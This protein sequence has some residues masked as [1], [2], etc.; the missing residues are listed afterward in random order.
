MTY[1]TIF[2]SLLLLAGAFS[3]R[4]Q[5]NT[6][7]LDL[8]ELNDSTTTE[9]I[10]ELDAEAD[11][12]A[13]FPLP[14]MLPLTDLPTIAYLPVVFDGVK[15]LD[16]VDLTDIEPLLASPNPAMNWVKEEAARRDRARRLKQ[17]YMIARPWQVHYNI[18]TLPEPPKMY[19]ANIDPSTQTIT[20]TEVVA[21]TDDHA[22]QALTTVE[23]HRVNW[24][25]KFNAALQFSQAFI[26]PNWYQGGTNN[27]NILADINWNV[28]LNNKFYPDW[29]LEAT[30]I[31]KMGINNA[32]QDTI[33][34]YLIS[35][36]LFQFNGTVGYKA[37]KNWYY[38]MTAQFKTQ[39]FNNYKPNSN[40]MKA[41]FMT[42]GE[43]N[44][45]LGMTYN[46]KNDPRR[47]KLDMSI[48]PL[49]YNL[50]VA[51]NRHI[52]PGNFG[53]AE[54]RKSVSDIGSNAEVKISWDIMWNINYS[55]RFFV[56][57]DYSYAQGDWEN[58]LSFSVNR[59]FSTRIFW[60]LRYDSSR[61]SDSSWRQWQLKE[62][63][64]FG[65]SY[66]FKTI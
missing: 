14:E 31:Y 20:V 1:R 22:T 35:Q 52:P 4:A 51:T 11:T 26:S 13:G 36:D 53:I 60:H 43:L 47:F 16:P 12:L 8:L 6:S 7:L 40:T 17:A 63:L 34:K 65:L 41:A 21:I 24:L 23:E 44:I 61:D 25:H 42:P 30:T 66:T 58:T 29:I 62:I 48:A 39:F 37:I 27:I 45:G 18:N 38:S 59:Y 32:P 2:L 50:K 55:S 54:G 49:S 56:F 15:Y 9:T 10:E 5:I 19:E 57:T 64:S 3:S 28:K 46:Y 33:H